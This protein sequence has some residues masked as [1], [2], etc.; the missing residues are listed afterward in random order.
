MPEP[1]NAPFA[2]QA[3]SPEAEPGVPTVR[4]PAQARG[5]AVTVLAVI[6]VACVLYL[7][8]T[9]FVSLLLGILIA[10][11]LSPLVAYLERVRIPR[12]A[13]TLIV[14]MGVMSAL[15]FGAYSLRGQMQTIIEQLPEAAK[16]LSSA[17]ARLGTDPAGSMRKVQNAAAEVEK[18]TGQAAEGA[19]IPR[20]SATHVVIDQ[21]G[22]TLSHLLL[23]GSRSALGFLGQAV[24]VLFLAFFLLAGGDTFKRKLVRLTGPSLSNRKITVKIL[25]DIDAS[26]QRY[27][28]MLLV[29]NALVALLAWVTFRW[30][31]LEN[32]GAWAVAFGVLHVIP[33][34]GPGVAAAATG[35]AAFMQFESFPMAL[36]VGAAS[37]VI[38]TLVG[39]FVTT[40]MTGRIAKMNP[41]AVFMSL[42][43]W[44]W[45][46]GIWGML[47]SIP[48]VVI[49]KVV[50]QHVEQL[51]P[52]AELLGE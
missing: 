26:V 28:F 25:D 23:E 48:I 6:A 9:F 37:L 38:A 27:L 29:T 51:K 15:G 43:F 52:V 45:L 39:T 20:K 24:M 40:W 13:G 32:A 36:L 47:L 5:I 50:S 18:A 17:L 31:G 7:A 16:T 33:Y 12:A 8:Q 10:Y 3:A 41:A 49:A 46:W 30:I 1:A 35:M 42:L 34:L 4:V 44:G 22:F 19:S 2:H 14:M 21:P 11:T